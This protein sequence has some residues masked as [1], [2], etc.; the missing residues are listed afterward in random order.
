MVKVNN[1]ETNKVELEFTID[2][3]SFDKACNAAY[4]K[5]VGKI[6]IPG[7]RKGKAPKA[8]I[9]KMYGAGV[10]YEDALNDLLPDAV[11]AAVKEADI[12]VVS[13]PE[14]DIDT[15]D[16]NGVVVKAKFFVY[17]AV[18]LKEYKG[19]KAERN[20]KSVTAT[21]V[22]EEIKRVQQRNARTI[23]VTDRAAKK[24]DTVNI[25]YAGSVD[26]VLFEGGSAQ[27]H[28]LKLGS[29]QFIPGF[30][31]QIIGHKIGEEF[32]V[33]VTFPEEYHAA[34][35][36]GKAAVF[37]TKINA[38]KYEELPKLDDEFAKD[39]SEFDTLAEYKADVKA[40][41]TERN[42]KA[43]DAEVNELLME[44]LRANL[45]CEVP[46]PM[47]EREAENM[48]RDYDTRLRMQGLDLA[49]YFKYT[50]QT[51]E[52]LRAQFMP[53]AEKQVKTRLALEKIAQTE[54]LEASEDEINEEYKK[55]SEAYGV[56]VDRVK[57][58]VDD[59]AIAEDIKVN[60]AFE[61]VRAEAKITKK[62]A[63]KKTE[64]KAEGEETA[65]EEKP[66][67]K[68]TTAKKTTKKAAEKK[69]E[70]K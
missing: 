11:E 31:D 50:G 2:K 69:T 42:E 51:L 12:K 19:L 13:A 70:D 9:E 7:F 40:K 26:G 30:E 44:A 39:V 60:K 8:M 5:Q 55:L 21:E 4:K 36:A 20:V 38:I 56:E 52:T 64:A 34:D 45:E 57:E 46:A 47:V 15:I 54:A 18:E 25:D 6:Q 32:D 28:D 16:E 29:G 17:P 41:L 33:E 1:I 63:A 67:A 58:L 66:A 27:G 23:D 65:E 49:T 10:F 3:E 24:N 53:E 61:L 37:A 22:N 48:V 14:Y 59:S 62:K 43:A 35:L 68:K